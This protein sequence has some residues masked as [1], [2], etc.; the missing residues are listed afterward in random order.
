MGQEAKLLWIDICHGVE[1]SIPKDKELPIVG[2]EVGTRQGS[3]L[4][5]FTDLT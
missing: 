3:C 4:A 1:G 2:R 5:D